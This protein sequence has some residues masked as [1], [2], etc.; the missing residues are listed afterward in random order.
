MKLKVL[1][2]LVILSNGLIAQVMNKI[3]WGTVYNIFHEE[4]ST[5][6]EFFLQVDK[7]VAAMKEANLN[8]IMILPMSQ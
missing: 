5:D 6:E 7:D 1:I 4:Y 8:H 3:I 2:I